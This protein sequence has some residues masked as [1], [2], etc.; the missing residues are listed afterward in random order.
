MPRQR[1]GCN[2]Q[3]HRSDARMFLFETLKFNCRIL[4]K[5][6]DDGNRTKESKLLAQSLVSIDLLLYF[7]SFGE[8]RHPTAHFLFKVNGSSHFIGGMPFQ[9]SLDL[10]RS[11]A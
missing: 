4:V 8:N 9:A 1:N 11:R 2:S 5:F 7:A 3:I 6:K 10:Q